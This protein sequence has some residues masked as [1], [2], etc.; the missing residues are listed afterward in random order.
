MKL[1][2]NLIFSFVLT[3]THSAS[4]KDGPGNTGGA[5]PSKNEVAAI[6][7]LLEGDALK[8]AMLNYIR[9]L[10]ISKVEIPQVKETFIAILKDGALENDIRTQGNYI[11]QDSCSDS[12]NK[13]VPASAKIGDV[14]GRICFD[15]NRLASAFHG[16]SAEQTMIELASVAFHEHVHHFQHPGELISKNEDEAYALSAYIKISAK[17]VQVPLLEWTADQ[18]GPF[19]PEDRVSIVGV[20]FSRDTSNPKLGLAFK[21]SRTGIIWGDNKDGLDGIVS[22]PEADAEEYC[23]SIGAALPTMEQ[24]AQL[25]VSLGYG[26]TQGY[27]IINKSNSGASSV[28]PHIGNDYFYWTNSHYIYNKNYCFVYGSEYGGLDYLHK[29]DNSDNLIAMTRCVQVP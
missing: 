8:S 14:G 13:N 20:R 9:T 27:S 28:L 10:N 18:S 6:K 4:A 19:D 12:F 15:T 1:L 17:V 24:Y 11:V 21:D 2:L 5:D 26:S 22:S 3:T 23:R 25:A 7:M 29:C 16:M